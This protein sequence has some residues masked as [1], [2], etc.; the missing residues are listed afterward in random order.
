MPRFSGGSGAA[1]VEEHIAACQACA[2]ELDGIRS[3]EAALMD[4][5]I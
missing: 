2:D 3:F 4:E 1:K 5:E